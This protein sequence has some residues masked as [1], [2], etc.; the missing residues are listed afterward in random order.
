M[1]RFH[2]VDVGLSTL[3]SARVSTMMLRP[4][5]VGTLASL[6]LFSVRMLVSSSHH[7]EPHPSCLVLPS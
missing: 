4:G 1:C 2:Q 6:S 7:T 3:P 5:S